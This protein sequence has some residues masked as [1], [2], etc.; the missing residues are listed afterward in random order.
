MIDQNTD[1]VP[2]WRDTPLR[3]WRAAVCY[4]ACLAAVFTLYWFAVKLL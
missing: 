2:S 1:F 3:G 4:V